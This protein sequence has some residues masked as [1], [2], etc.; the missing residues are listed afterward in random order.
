MIAR[1]CPIQPSPQAFSLARC[2]SV[3]SQLTI[4]SR[5][6]RAE[7]AWDWGVSDLSKNKK[8]YCKLGSTVRENTKTGHN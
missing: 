4:E 2:L 7:N 1:V 6:D 3:T 5:I 8:D